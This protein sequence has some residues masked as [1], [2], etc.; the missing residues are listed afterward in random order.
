MD[1]RHEGV[2][3]PPPL[4]LDGEGVDAIEMHR[5]RSARSQGVAA[6]FLLFVADIAVEKSNA[7]RCCLDRLVDL[8]AA[9]MPILPSHGI[10]VGEDGSFA[11]P[12]MV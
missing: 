8:L 4:D 9:D 6:D 3:A 7:R 1:V 12:A 11:I 5:H 2:A 10:V